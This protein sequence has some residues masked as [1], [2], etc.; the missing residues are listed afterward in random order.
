MEE[1]EGPRR[2]R[3]SFDRDWTKG[4]I[5]GNL[6]RLAWPQMVTSF[7]ML[8]GPT[9]DM[10]WVGRLGSASIAGV[11]VAGMAVM[12][13]NAARQGLTTGNRALLARAVGAQDFKEANHVLQQSIVVSTLFSLVTAVIGI[14]LAEEILMLLGLELEVVSEGAAYMRIQ[15][16]GAVFMSFGMMATAAMQASGDAITPMKINIATRVIHT[17]L[18]PFLIFGWWIFPRMGVSG[19]AVINV[20]TQAVGTAIGMWV[21]FTGRTRVRLTLKGF[22]FDG[23]MIWRIV[24]IGI[25]STITGIERNLANFVFTWLIV[26]FGTAAVAAHSLMQRVDSFLHPPAQAVGQASGVLAAQNLGA[27]QPERAEKTGW[28]AAGIYTAVMVFGSIIIWFWAEYL[29]RIFNS[30]PELVR[31]TATFM[32]IEIVS[33]LTFGLVV[34]LSTCLNGVGDT[35]IPMITTL[36]TMWGVQIPMAYFLPKITNLGVYGIRWGIVTAIIFRAAIYTIYFK[37]GRWKRIRV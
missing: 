3:A 22:R 28:L 9:I 21:L 18:A 23:T 34:V 36:V 19:V 30:E 35:L 6:L 14:I 24:K 31:I 32:R 8:F 5:T 33:D 12:L 2:R 4:S 20:A 17:G 7:L 10:I 27:K 25:P 13:L 11:G 26:P 15:F 1:S 37:L 29:V 16:V